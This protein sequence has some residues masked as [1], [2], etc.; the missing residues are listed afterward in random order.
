MCIKKAEKV[1]FLLSDTAPAADIWIKRLIINSELHDCYIQWLN[2]FF[3]MSEVECLGRILRPS[4]SLR[5]SR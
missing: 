2:V 4:R 1:L 5:S 3:R